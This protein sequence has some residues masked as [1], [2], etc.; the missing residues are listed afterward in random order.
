MRITI[1]GKPCA[2]NIADLLRQKVLSLVSNSFREDSARIYAEM[3][4][5]YVPKD[6]GRLRNSYT[7]NGKYITYNTDYAQKVYEIP[8]KHYT[9][10]GTT[11]HWDEYAKPIIWEDYE[12]AITELAKEYFSRTK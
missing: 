9:T 2:R 4:D 3:I 7:V 10:P 5:P 8:A 11:H 12:R 1:N 6:T